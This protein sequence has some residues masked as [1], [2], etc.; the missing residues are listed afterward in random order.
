[1]KKIR[2]NAKEKAKLWKIENPELT[3][4]YQLENITKAQEWNKNH[5]EDSILRQQQ[6]RRK[7]LLDKVSKEEL[8]IQNFLET[9]GYPIERQVLIEN[10]YFD[11]RIN[12]FLIEYNGSTYHCTDYKNKINPESS[13]SMQ[14]F[15]SKKYHLDLRNLALRN[16]YKLIQIWDYQWLH[17]K[18]LMKKLIKD[19]LSETAD[20]R[21]YMEN[22]ILNNDFG[23]V[24]EGEQ[25]EPKGIWISTSNEKTIVNDEY[26]KG[27]VLIYNSGYTKIS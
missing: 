14:T 7:N 27:K 20:Y 6:N 9:I 23:F 19:Q 15:K 13:L 8:E 25:L 17:Q 24:T 3:K 26:H 11:F 16:K 1:M 2:D 4:Q 10:H 12:N 21:D 18:E 22:N 5:K